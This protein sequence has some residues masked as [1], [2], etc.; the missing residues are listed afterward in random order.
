MRIDITARVGMRSVQVEYDD[1]QPNGERS[2]LANLLQSSAAR[3][4]IQAPEGA[5]I[6]VNGGQVDPRSYVLEQ[7]DIIV[8]EVRSADKS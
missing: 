4:Q 8:F 3:S 6:R 5:D 2:T 1:T 7:G